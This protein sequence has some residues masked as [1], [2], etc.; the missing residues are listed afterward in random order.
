MSQI[1]GLEVK[2]INAS[3]LT[4]SY[5]N[6]G[7]VTGNP[8]YSGEIVNDSDVDIYISIDGSTDNIKVAADKSTPLNFYSRHNTLL[9]GAYIFKKGQ[10]LQIKSATSSGSGTVY[11]NLLTTR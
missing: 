6:L 1:S 9:Q 7:S 11:A 4:G 10:Q 5:Q 8:V 3:A 2:E